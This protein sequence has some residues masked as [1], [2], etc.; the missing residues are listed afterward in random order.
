MAARPWLLAVPIVA[1][2]FVAAPFVAPSW[3]LFIL[4]LALAK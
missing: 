3:I 4:H 1:G 2:L